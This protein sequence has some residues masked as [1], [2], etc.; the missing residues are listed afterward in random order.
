M[1]ANITKEP[2]RRQ[3]SLAKR[4]ASQGEVGD[5]NST[6]RREAVELP[7]RGEKIDV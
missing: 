5:R 4:Y 7:E 6:H 2:H 1:Q 3:A